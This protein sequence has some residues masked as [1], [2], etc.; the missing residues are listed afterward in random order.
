MNKMKN[1]RK[2]I[3]LGILGALFFISGLYYQSYDPIKSIA[4][5]I[6]GIGTWVSGLIYYIFIPKNKEVATLVLGLIILH[7]GVALILLDKISNPKMLGL[8]VFISGIVI[9]LNSGFSDYLK[10]RAQKK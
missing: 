3:F 7:A 4:F 5:Q 8:L 6:L 2:K 10:Q 1:S 9:V